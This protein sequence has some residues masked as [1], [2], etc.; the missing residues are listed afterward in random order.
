LA[1]TTE[2]LL[3]SDPALLDNRWWYWK[4]PFSIP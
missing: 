4:K 1:L 2:K 3:H